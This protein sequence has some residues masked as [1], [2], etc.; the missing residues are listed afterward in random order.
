MGSRG[1]VPSRSDQRR[2]TNSPAPKK[3]AAGSV[4][5]VPAADPEWHP[6]ARRWFESLAGS[7]QSRFYEPSD[8]AAAYVLAESI[9]REFK[10]Q[11][12]TVGKGDDAHFEM[13]EMAPKGASLA[14]W[15]K[16]MAAL[17]V[18]EGERRRAGLELQRGPVGANGVEV[19][20]VSE[21]DEWRD[22]LGRSAG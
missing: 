11:P 8:W 21:L 2:R 15:L 3:A 18:T 12:F 13:V 4:P 22:R 9:S 16:G 14:A 6:V 1:P 20:D 17:M 10:P 7:G 5:D 19:G